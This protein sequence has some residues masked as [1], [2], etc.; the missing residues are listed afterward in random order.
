MPAGRR[1]APGGQPPP[2]RSRRSWGRRHRKRRPSRPLRGVDI[3]PIGPTL[4][5]LGGVV[6]RPDEIGGLL[7]DGQLTAVWCPAIRGG[8]GSARRR[9]PGRAALGRA[10]RPRPWRSAAA[11]PAVRVDVGMAWSPAGRGPL[12]AAEL[13]DAIRPPSSSWSTRPAHPLVA[14]LIAGWCARTV[15]WC[16]PGVGA[17]GGPPERAEGRRA[18]ASSRGGVTRSA[19]GRSSTT[20][21]S[22]DRAAIRCS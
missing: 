19:D 10:R 8:H 2:A 5:R 6:A 3:A 11:G 22:G 15:A 4:R 18:V 20:R 7:R 1:G 9:P 13:A 17:P 14:G 16:L 12:A 21:W